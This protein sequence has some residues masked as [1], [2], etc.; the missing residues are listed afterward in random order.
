[1]ARGRT[2]LPRRPRGGLKNRGGGCVTEA[3]AF[4]SRRCHRD[5]FLVAIGKVTNG[6]SAF[7]SWLAT[8]GLATGVPAAAGELETLLHLFFSVFYWTL[9]FHYSEGTGYIFF[10]KWFVGTSTP[11]TIDKLPH[12]LYRR[13][14]CDTF[15][16]SSQSYKEW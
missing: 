8:Q 9:N 6:G 11:M 2:R 12:E 7:I 10:Y 16:R 3:G 14:L 13:L 15:S 1:M 5:V 4:G